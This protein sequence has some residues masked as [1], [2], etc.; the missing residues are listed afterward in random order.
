MEYLNTFRAIRMVQQANVFADQLGWGFVNAAVKRNGAVLSDPP[1]GLF[2]EM[3]LKVGG[4][5]SDN[6]KMP[7]KPGKGRLSGTGMDPLM[8]VFPYPKIKSDIDI[9]QFVAVKI[10]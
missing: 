4:C 7:G 8:V 9:S 5:R 6:F 10:W 3:I 1:S 2:A